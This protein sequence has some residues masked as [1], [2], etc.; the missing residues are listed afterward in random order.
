MAEDSAMAQYKIFP[1]F[2][3]HSTLFPITYIEPFT[4][5]TVQI[6]GYDMGSEAMRAG[7]TSKRL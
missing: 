2:S 3:S 6:L 7:K 4:E 1:S 5:Q